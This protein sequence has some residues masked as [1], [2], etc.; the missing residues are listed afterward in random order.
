[1]RLGVEF[2]LKRRITSQQIETARSLLD[3]GYTADQAAEV[4]RD[5]PK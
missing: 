2:G 1:M 3:K 5:N 4:V